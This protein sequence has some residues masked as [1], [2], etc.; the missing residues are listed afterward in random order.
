[1]SQ[2][3]LPVLPALKPLAIC[4]VCGRK[5]YA[6]ARCW[7]KEEQKLGWWDRLPSY[8]HPIIPEGCPL[9][10]SDWRWKVEKQAFEVYEDDR[11]F[12]SSDD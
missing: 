11:F 12:G 9:R 7:G 8:P 10:D 2:P 4:G 6:D 3:D 5:L 1:V